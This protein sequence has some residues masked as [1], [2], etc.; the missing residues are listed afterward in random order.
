MVNDFN[1]T[2]HFPF[3]SLTYLTFMG[4]WSFFYLQHLNEVVAF[5]VPLFV[6]EMTC[7]VHDWGSL[8]SYI[9]SFS[10]STSTYS[11]QV[12]VAKDCACCI[13]MLLPPR[14]QH[15]ESLN[16]FFQRLYVCCRSRHK[17]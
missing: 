4:M 9:V 15:F 5:L 12:C 11:T 7:L 17:N 3:L 6:C 1:M 10:M 2:N 8:S 16:R 13:E 14:L